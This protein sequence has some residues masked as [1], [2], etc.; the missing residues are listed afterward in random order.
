MS[1]FLWLF[2][3]GHGG[4][5]NGKYVTKGKRSPIWSDGSQYFEGVGNR[6]IVKLLMQK[7]QSRG[8]ECI[9]ILEGS[10]EDISLQNRAYKANQIYYNDSRAILISIHSDGFTKES[11]NGFSVYTSVGETK[12]DKIATKFSKNMEL[13][14]PKHKSRKDYTD[15]DADKEANFYIIKKTNCPAVLIENFFMTNYRECKLL[16]DTEF[17]NRLV[18]CHFQTILEME[19]NQTFIL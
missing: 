3:A 19:N 9:D 17:I 1:K 8:V 2:D 16:M 6:N 5:V 13:Y 7:L 18:D 10:Q 15:N 14:F 12:S 11:A 4:V